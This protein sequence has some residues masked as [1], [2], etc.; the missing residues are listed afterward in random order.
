MKPHTTSKGRANFGLKGNKDGFPKPAEIEKPIC[1][2]RH[3]TVS[4]KLPNTTNWFTY[5]ATTQSP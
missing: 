2:H 3:K 1:Y 5:I 4:V